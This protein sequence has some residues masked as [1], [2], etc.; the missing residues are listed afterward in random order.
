MILSA[1]TAEAA[2]GSALLGLAVGWFLDTVIVRWVRRFQERE[3]PSGKRW[4]RTWLVIVLTA[5]GFVLAYMQFD[6][7]WQ[8]VFAWWFITVM[9][10]ITFIDLEQMIIPNRI[11]LPSAL[12]GLA[13]AIALDPD[14]WWVYV[15]AAAGAALFL[16]LLA[17][18]W[19]GGMGA[20]DV[21]MAL[22]M[23]AVLGA[24]VVVALF[25]AFMLGAVVGV[26]LMASKRKTRHDAIPFGP[27]LALGSVIA[28]LFGPELVDWYVSLLP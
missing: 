7:I 9:I 21:K 8:L 16:F 18:V 5:A 24:L 10:L 2:V 26:V 17:L 20:G 12:I 15:V 28:L 27:Y 23:G 3:S 25:L 11:V 14:M 4:S 1:F 19:R 22:F 13:A 6:T